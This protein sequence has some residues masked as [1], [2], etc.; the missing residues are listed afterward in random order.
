MSDLERRSLIDRSDSIWP[1]TKQ[2]DL[3]NISRST[4]YYKSVSSDCS[5]EDL[6]LMKHLD[7]QYLLTPFYGARVTAH[8]LFRLIFVA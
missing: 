4:Y 2:C 7:K 5:D 3:L 1:I 6:L 8:P